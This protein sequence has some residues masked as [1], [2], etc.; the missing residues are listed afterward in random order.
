MSAGIYHFTIEQGAVFGRIFDWVDDA[1][2]P[3][4]LT[5]YTAAMQLRETYASPV[6]LTWTAFLTVAGPEGRVSVLVP[7]PQTAAITLA[8]GVYDLELTPPS[9]AASTFRLLQGQWDL[10]AEVTK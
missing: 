6:A 9:G 4:D 10:A 7:A 5:G 8:R 3:V 2:Q 1:D